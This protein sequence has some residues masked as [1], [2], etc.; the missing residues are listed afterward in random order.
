MSTQ[1]EKIIAANASAYDEI[2]EH[3]S[4]TRNFLWPDLT[5]ILE[6]VQAHYTVL[7]I[8]C[9]NGRLYQLFDEKS[10]AKNN[11]SVPSG[12]KYYGQDIS[13]RLIDL[14]KN[15]YP[16]G[17]FE[18][19]DMRDMSYPD[20]M[21][22]L[23]V[24]LVAFHHL[25]DRGTQLDALREMYRV[26]KPSGKVILLN[27]NADSD[28]VGEKLA[29]GD[30]RELGGRLF[31]VPWKDQN[32][33]VRGIRTYFGFTPESISELADEVGLVVSDQYYLRHGERVGVGDGM[34]LVSVFGKIIR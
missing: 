8:G 3:F 19:S 7:D 30:Y 4:S 33:V 16:D 28:W 29:G 17:V 10:M 14:A 2:A 22:D 23:I 26:L 12:V 6:S 13:S 34:N 20:E 31:E 5:F 24:S 21:F 32:G 11:I 15:T 25:P 18:V 27:W 9:G 1:S